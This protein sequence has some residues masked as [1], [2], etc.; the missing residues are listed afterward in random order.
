MKLRCAR[1]SRFV[2][3]RKGPLGLGHLCGLHRRERAS[4]VAPVVLP[5][6]LRVQVALEAARVVGVVPSVRGVVRLTKAPEFVL[7][8]EMRAG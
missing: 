2:D 7:R 1:C 4:G 8:A 6:A 3:P 5:P